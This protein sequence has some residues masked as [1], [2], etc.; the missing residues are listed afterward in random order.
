MT[1]W[2]P[3]A[4]LGHVELYRLSRDPTERVDLSR[5]EPARTSA[6]L[7][8]LQRLLRAA[9]A[10]GPGVTG[11]SERSPPCPRLNRKLNI[12]EVCCTSVLRDEV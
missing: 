2:L 8:E 1:D 11:W 5:R 10:S 4:E 9:A 7:R 3:H 12:T 6:M